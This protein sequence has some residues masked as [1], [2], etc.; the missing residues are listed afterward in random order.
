MSSRLLS[1]FQTLI[2]TLL[3]SELSAKHSSTP[4]VTD[5]ACYIYKLNLTNDPNPDQKLIILVNIQY[6]VAPERATAFA[7]VLLRE[8]RPANVVISGAISRH[9]FRGKLSADDTF[10]F[11]F[12]TV[13]QRRE[14]NEALDDVHY[15]PSGSIIDGL[16]AAL[17]SRCQI[18]KLKASLDVP[19]PEA[20]SSVVK[21]L[22][23]VFEK[24]CP[25][26]EWDVSVETPF[27][28]GFRTELLLYA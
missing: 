26:A 4:S 24:L 27:Y 2:G 7:K 28:I 1:S 25:G 18:L 5:K 15:F 8:M 10:I 23:S 17:I 19:W 22:C 6:S 11:K 21:I 20:E 14:N 3:L 13:E 12:E 9:Q 16:A